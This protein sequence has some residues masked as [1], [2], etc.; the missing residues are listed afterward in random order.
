M[1]LVIYGES[2][3]ATVN[4]H[5]AHSKRAGPKGREQLATVYMIH[6]I[7]RH[8]T[9]KNVVCRSPL[10]WCEMAAKITTPN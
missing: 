2:T 4:A 9:V 8:N 6:I 7:V 3:E 10:N 1:Q 5:L